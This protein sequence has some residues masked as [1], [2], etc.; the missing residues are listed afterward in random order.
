MDAAYSFQNPTAPWGEDYPQNIDVMLMGN[1]TQ[2]DFV[3]V[4]I[5]DLDGSAATPLT[6]GIAEERRSNTLTMLIDDVEMTAGNDY[7]VDFRASD[8]NNVTGY[9]F[10]LNFDQNAADFVSVEAGAL[11]VDE[12][13][14]GFTML[15]EGIIT[16]SFT[17]MGKAISVGNDEV[18]FSIN[19]SATANAT[20]NDVIGLTNEYTLAEAYNDESEVSDVQLAFN[21]AGL[22]T[23][24][25]GE[26]ELFQNRPNPYS[27]ST[28]VGFNLPE[29]SNATLS[30]YDVSGKM[31]KVITASY[32]RGYNEVEINRNDLGAAGVLYYQLDTDANSAVKKMIILE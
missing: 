17:E 28:V 6:G 15:N 25:G 2:E 1:E 13:N 21:N 29:A 5:G 9:Q 23:T 7:K 3:A 4:K 27:E 18:L 30:I 32:A 22:V 26:F 16:T 11:N 14:F 24:A 31:L 8:F 12:S 20:L 19:F 10:T